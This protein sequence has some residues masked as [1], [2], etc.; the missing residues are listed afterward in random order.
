[1]NTE[2]LSRPDHTQEEQ[3]LFQKSFARDFE[4]LKTNPA[5]SPSFCELHVTICKM[6]S[7]SLYT[8]KEAQTIV[9][10]SDPP[11]KQLALLKSID[12]KGPQAI[13]IFYLLLHMTDE[14]AYGQ[15][16]SCKDNDEKMVLI[17]KMR[18]KSVSLLQSKVSEMLKTVKPLFSQGSGRSATS[19]ATVKPFKTIKKEEKDTTLDTNGKNSLERKNSTEDGNISSSE[20]VKL[21]EQQRTYLRRGWGIKKDDEFFHFIIVCFALGAILVCEYY[22]SDWTVSVGFGLISFA[23]LETIGIYFG[24]VYR[25]QTVVEQLLPLVG[26]FTF[27]FKKN[28]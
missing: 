11:D 25:I 16:P 27:G 26:R 24:L 3:D 7:L 9:K 19:V 4:N 6:S 15:L 13:A 18:D 8:E 1:M 28:N 10:L 20:T 14:K 17:S 23:T 2:K 12:D 21:E 22:Y 5:I